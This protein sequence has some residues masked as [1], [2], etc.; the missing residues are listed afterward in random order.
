MRD[1][2]AEGWVGSRGGISEWDEMGVGSTAL[3]ARVVRLTVSGQGRYA[4]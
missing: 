1:D 2:V 3:Q 4:D